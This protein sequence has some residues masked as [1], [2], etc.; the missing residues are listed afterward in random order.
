VIEFLLFIIVFFDLDEIFFEFDVRQPSGI[1]HWNRRRAA[2]QSRVATLFHPDDHKQQASRKRK[3]GNR[4]NY[5]SPDAFGIHQN[6]VTIHPDQGLFN[7]RVASTSLNRT[8]DLASYMQCGFGPMDSDGLSPT[9]RC[10]EER[11]EISGPPLL[12]RLKSRCW[13]YVAHNQSGHE[14]CNENGFFCLQ[15]TSLRGLVAKEHAVNC[16]SL[17]IASADIYPV[18]FAE[19][20]GGDLAS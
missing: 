2:N 9:A 4:V 3:T 14:E 12:V 8:I 15:S 1:L 17:A 16:R 13:Q 7:F 10:N 19:N 5:K 18:F 20:G 11:I 6:P